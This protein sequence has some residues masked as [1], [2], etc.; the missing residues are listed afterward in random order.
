MSQ[1]F[2]YSFTSA[3]VP[4]NEDINVGFTP[5]KC[6]VYVQTTA[7]SSAN[8][9]VVQEAIR[10]D[11]MVNGEALIRKNTNGAATLTSAFITSGGISFL[12]SGAVYGSSITGFTN[13]NPG[14]ITVSNAAAAGFA[15]GDLVQVASVAN[16]GAGTSLNGQFTVA[17]VSGNSITLTANTSAYGVYVSGGFLTRVSNSSGVPIATQNI[18]ENFVRIGTGAQAASSEIHVV[19]YGKNSVV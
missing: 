13:A 8:P 10:T 17:S 14:V 4:V 15:A 1:L 5:A 18:G 12:T 3:A 11:T 19:I 2:T 6:E 9:G 7:G 16:T